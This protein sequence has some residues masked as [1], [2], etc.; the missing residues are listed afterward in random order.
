MKKRGPLTLSEIVDQFDKNKFDALC[1]NGTSLSPKK[2]ASLRCRLQ[3]NNNPFL[4]IGPMKVEEVSLNPYI[5][6]YHDLVHDEEID[7]IHDAAKPKV[8]WKI[9]SVAT[10]PLSIF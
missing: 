10:F 2:Q 3:T 8:K 5:A 4:K 1:R 9:Y 7:Y 6:V